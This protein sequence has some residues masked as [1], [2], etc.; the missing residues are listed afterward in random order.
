MRS[1]ILPR[2]VAPAVEPPRVATNKK[3][4]VL[5][6]VQA[7]TL[8]EGARER[9]LGSIWLVMLAWPGLDLGDRWSREQSSAIESGW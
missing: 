7:R 8:L 9:P 5:T 2:N 6:E 4:K 1:D 3:P